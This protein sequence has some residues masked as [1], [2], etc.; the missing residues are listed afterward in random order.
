MK[1]TAV[2]LRDDS[3]SDAVSRLLGSGE[4]ES[5]PTQVGASAD[6]GRDEC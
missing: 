3:A 1:R 6:G 2:T 4:K 5:V